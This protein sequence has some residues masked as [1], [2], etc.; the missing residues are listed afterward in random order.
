LW[1][2]ASQ[3]TV[4]YNTFISDQT[5]FWGY[6]GH[7]NRTGKSHPGPTT[8]LKIDRTVTQQPFI[9]NNIFYQSQGA[10]F[11]KAAVAETFSDA[12]SS[13]NIVTPV[14]PLFLNASLADYHLLVGSPAIQAAT[15]I[16]P[17]FEPA[18]EYDRG[19][20]SSRITWADSGAFS[21]R[22]PIIART[23]LRDFRFGQELQPQP[24]LAKENPIGLYM[25]VPISAPIPS[26]W[27]CA[28]P[29][30]QGLSGLK[31]VHDRF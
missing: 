16:A 7:G 4:V 10:A 30:R 14:N 9:V 5:T 13:S 21:F 29:G 1:D 27:M 2:A 26:Q 6:D 24:S 18:Q 8:F 22:S 19:T 31:K 25:A 12:L 15:L 23:R 17:T 20:V 3:L 11:L 28:T